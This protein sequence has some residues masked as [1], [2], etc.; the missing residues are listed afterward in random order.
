MFRSPLYFAVAHRWNPCFRARD[1]QE[2]HLLRRHRRQLAVRERPPGLARG[3]S[4]HP[5]RICQ[6][7][8]RFVRIPVR[9]AKELTCA[10]DI[11]VDLVVEEFDGNGN[12]IYTGASTNLIYG[13]F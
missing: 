9:F 1:V 4:A 11:L 8:L 10:C 13:S 3:I 6:G 7:Q 2:L 5:G 12:I